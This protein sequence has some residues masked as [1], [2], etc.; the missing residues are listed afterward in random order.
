VKTAELIWLNFLLA[1]QITS[2]KRLV[3]MEKFC[4]KKMSIFNSFEN[5]PVV[6]PKKKH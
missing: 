6:T 1:A 2:G 3:D 5:A 4:P